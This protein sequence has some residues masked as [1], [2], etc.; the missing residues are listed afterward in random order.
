VSPAQRP[1]KHFLTRRAAPRKRNLHERVAAGIGRLEELACRQNDSTQE[2]ARRKRLHAESEK[3]SR[4]KRRQNDSTCSQND[5]TAQVVKAVDLDQVQ[6]LSTNYLQRDATMTPRRVTPHPKP[7]SGPVWLA[8]STAYKTRYG[9]DPVRNAK[10]N[11]QI[12]QFVRRIP[13]EAAAEVAAF[14]LTHPG[15]KYAQNAHPV[16]ML[17][18]DAEKL[19]TEWTTGKQITGTGARQQERTAE[20]F[21]GWSRHLSGAKDGVG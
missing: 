3:R 16:G 21:N 19:H 7:A 5:A 9:A 10:V 1:P 6:E 18:Q 12:A 14:Y 11:G 8:Y 20:N 13:E 17:L 15:A 4:A 2:L